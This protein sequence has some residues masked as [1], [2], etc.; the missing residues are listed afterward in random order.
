MGERA[1]TRAE[2][3]MDDRAP[4]GT[5]PGS[6]GVVAIS[7]LQVVLDLAPQPLALPVVP[8][9]ALVGVAVTA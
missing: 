4:G 3:V 8:R 9:A 7:V 2:P 1:P 5:R 6:G